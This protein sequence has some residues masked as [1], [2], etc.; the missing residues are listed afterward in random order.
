MK[1]LTV[2]ASADG[3]YS[4]SMEGPGAFNIGSTSATFDE[5][6]K[7]LG[8]MGHIKNLATAVQTADMQSAASRQTPGWGM[9]SGAASA[10]VDRELRLECVRLAIQAG[11]PHDR[12]V[13]WAADLEERLTRTEASHRI[14]CASSGPAEG[15]YCQGNKNATAS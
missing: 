5:V 10:R 9:L 1:K 13:S 11:V 14:T 7:M 4:Y 8:H 2:I 15:C 6:Q 12:V 3:R